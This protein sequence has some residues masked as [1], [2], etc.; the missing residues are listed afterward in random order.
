MNLLAIN[1]SPRKDF[2]TGTLLKYSIEGAVSKGANAEIVHL[3]D[4]NYKGCAS[5]FNCKLKGG[6]NYGRCSVKDELE[7]ILKKIEED[8]DALILGSPIYFS[9]VTGQMRCFLERLLFPYMVYDEN[10]STLFKRKM[11]VGF[12][13]T[14]GVN[15][16][17]MEELSYKKIF[18]RTEFMIS[19]VF[20]SVEVMYVT[21]TYQ[22]TDYSKYVAPKFD[23]EAKERRRREVFPKD[24]QRAYEMG[25][26]FAE[27]IMAK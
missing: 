11:P 22:F 25:K 16:K 27:S 17:M 13:Y 24:C 6:K 19:R 10:Y 5:C 18:E 3:Y 20:G 4:L 9:S 2:N 26:R 12:I 8:V 1:G 14:M 23:V 7:P 21:D 15:E